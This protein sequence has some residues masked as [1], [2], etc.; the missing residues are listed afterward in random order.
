MFALIWREQVTPLRRRICAL[1]ASAPRTSASGSTGW[2]TTTRQDAAGSARHGY[3]VTGHPGTTLL[4]AAR[5]AAW[6]TPNAG[7]QNDTDSNWQRRREQQR[8]LG[9]NGNGFGLNLS[10]AASLTGWA[11]PQ[12]RDYKGAP[13]PG[14]ELTHNARPLNEQVRLVAAWA[15]PLV[16]DSRNSAGD[17]TNPRDLPRQTRL[18]HGMTSNGSPAATARLGQL[19]PAFSRWLMGFPAA[20]DDCAP[21]ATPSSRRSPLRS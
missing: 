9:R 4:D 19:N 15:T 1:R 17:G 16:R 8:A 5:M 12:S 7:P 21:T 13:N 10:M 3:M 20:W 11:T 18:L 2:P 6:P 14:N